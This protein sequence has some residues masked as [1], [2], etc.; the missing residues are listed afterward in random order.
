[1]ISNMKVLKSISVFV[2]GKN[3]FLKTPYTGVDP[4]TSLTGATT[5]Q[6]LDYFNMPGTKGYTFGL[7]FLF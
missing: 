4:E 2:T 5:S 3:L 1:M 7:K 6:G